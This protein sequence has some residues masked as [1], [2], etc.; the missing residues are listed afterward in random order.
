MPVSESFHVMVKPTGPICNLDC[1]YCFYLDKE[2]LYPGTR[3]WAMSD[4]VLEKYIREY[5]KAQVT[6]AITFAWQGGEPTLVGVD[7]F[8]KVVNL[9][10][11]YSDGRKI[12]NTLQTNGVLLND[13]WCEF[14]ADNQFLVGLSIDGPKEIHDRYRVFKGGQPSFD[15]VMNGVNFLLKHKV[16]FNTLTCIQRDNSFKAPEVYKFLKGIGSRFMQFIPIV[17][18]RQPGRGVHSTGGDPDVEDYSVEPLQFGKFLTDVFDEWV[19]RDVGQY[20]IQIFDVS[21]E[22]WLGRQPSLCIF[23][24]KCGSALAMEHNGDV[25]SC[26]HFVNPENKLGNLMQES[27]EKIIFS[28]KQKEFGS[29][30]LTTLPKYCMECSVRFACNGECPKNRFIH[31]PDGVEGLNYLCAGYKHFFTHIDPHM[32]FMAREL[33]EGRAPANVMRWVREMDNGFPN[34]KAGRND[35][36]PCGSGLKF[37]NCCRPKRSIW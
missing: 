29:D 24:E 2:E 37:K 17:E 16:E 26:D 15:K 28:E 36:C 31:T 23:R 20:F 1:E 14:L 27:L 7:F 19:R 35:P 30:K 13:E 33:S 12:E 5:I 18:R 11:K 22:M 32:R 6:P 21:L 8:R 4:D 10:N 3:K 34:S 9:Q 25:Y